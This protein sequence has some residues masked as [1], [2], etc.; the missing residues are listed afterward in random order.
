ME[1][2]PKPKS[3]SNKYYLQKFKMNKNC[4]YSKVESSPTMHYTLWIIS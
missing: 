3:M 1:E 4:K 2:T